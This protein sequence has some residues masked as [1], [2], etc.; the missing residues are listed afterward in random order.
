MEAKIIQLQSLDQLEK[1]IKAF[2]RH[3]INRSQ[4]YY[5]KCL[6][7]NING[8][9]IT[10]FAV[11][12]DEIAGCSHLKYKSDYLYF[13]ESGIPEINDLN[14]F[15]EYQRQGI[16]NRLMDEFEGQISR[17]HKKIGIGVGLYKDYGTAQRI[18]CR[19][20]YIPDGNGVSYNN[21]IVKPGSMICV[22]DDLILYFIK[23]LSQY[24]LFFGG[25]L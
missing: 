1:W 9:R 6:E 23:D 19:R 16:A 18:Y 17:T 4:E 13:L 7:E 22:D 25:S 5:H 14:V 3:D 21:Q 20:G 8:T 10:L 15:I 12:N 24:K 2:E 11:V